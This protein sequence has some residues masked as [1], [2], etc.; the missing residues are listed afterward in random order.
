MNCSQSD[1]QCRRRPYID[2]TKYLKIVSAETFRLFG[3]TAGTY[4]AR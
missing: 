4:S 1:L 2:G 3:Y